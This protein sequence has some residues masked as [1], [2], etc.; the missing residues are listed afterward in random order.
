MNDYAHVHADRK[1]LIVHLVAVPM[2][3]VGSLGLIR[4]LVRAEW[5]SALVAILVMAIAMAMQGL[6][7][8]G[9]KY[10][11]LP[12]AGPVDAMKRILV[13]QYFRFPLFVWSGRWHK[14]WSDAGPEG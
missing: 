12:F 2:F 1:N 6:G 7:H 4:F 13:E 14:A 5:V 3:W 9:E 8:K 10:P 11:P